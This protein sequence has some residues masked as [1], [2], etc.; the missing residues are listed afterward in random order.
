MKKVIKKTLSFLVI[1]IF[2]G[3]CTVY[4]NIRRMP[5]TEFSDKTA[6]GYKLDVITAYPFITIPQGNLYCVANSSGDLDCR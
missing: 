5:Q 4:G 1:A 6:G 3:A 2:L